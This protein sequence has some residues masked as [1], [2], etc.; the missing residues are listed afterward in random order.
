ME[1]RRGAPSGLEFSAR[2][3]LVARGRPVRIGHTVGCNTGG[4]GTRGA[5]IQEGGSGWAGIQ[6]GGHTVGRNTGGGQ[7]VGLNAGGG[8]T[9]GWHKARAASSS[10]EDAHCERGRKES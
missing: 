10:R 4:G 2:G 3:E 1:C 8:H 7:T 9:V 5:G 6:E